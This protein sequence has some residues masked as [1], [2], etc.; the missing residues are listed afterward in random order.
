MYYDYLNKLITTKLINK[1][2]ATNL[3]V[4]P[5][6]TTYIINV[7]GNLRIDFAY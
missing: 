5:S 6:Y 1:L 7:S 4:T 3:R 2:D